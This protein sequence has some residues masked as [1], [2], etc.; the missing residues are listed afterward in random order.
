LSSGSCPHLCSPEENPL[1]TESFKWLSI[2]IGKSQPVFQLRSHYGKEP[3]SPST[4]G[5]RGDLVIAGAGEKVISLFKL[6]IMRRVFQI[7]PSADEALAVL[8]V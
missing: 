8:S 7:F 6:T 1:K 4:L 2:K 5:G 3:L